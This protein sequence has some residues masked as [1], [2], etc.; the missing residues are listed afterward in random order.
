MAAATGQGYLAYVLSSPMQAESGGRNIGIPCLSPALRKERM[1][2]D[3]KGPRKV[4][5]YTPDLEPGAWIEIYELAMD[6]LDV[7]EAVCDKYFTMMFEGTAH[8]WLKNL[9]PNSINT[10][11][12]LKERFVKNFRGTC[13]R[14]MTIVHL[15]HC[16]QRPD[17]SAHHWTRRV[18]EVI[19]SSDDISAAH[20]VLILEKNCHYQPLVLKLGRLKRKVQDM[21]ELMDT[22]I[23]YGESDDTKDPGEDDDKTSTTRRGTHP[24]ANLKP[25]GEATVTPRVK[26][27][28]GSRK[29]PLISL[30]ILTLGTGTS[31]R[32]KGASAGKTT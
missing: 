12:E 6:M 16:V 24:E 19:H 15:Q 7:N 31:V 30:P 18:A 23:R 27:R 29:A 11:P 14:P 10:W 3:F 5:N 32:R 13:K 8:T 2:K 26:G 1:S 25:R 21:G 17:E 20:A 22:L 9:P 28:K 4:P